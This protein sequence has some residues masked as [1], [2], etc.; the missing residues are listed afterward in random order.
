MLKRLREKLKRRMREALR[1][2]RIP[3]TIN[4]SGNVTGNTKQTIES[5]N[6]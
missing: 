1:R 4:R 3:T 5:K 2:K 6:K